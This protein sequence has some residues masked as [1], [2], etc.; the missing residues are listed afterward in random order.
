MIRAPRLIAL[1]APLVWSA[2]S[3]SDGPN[4][5]GGVRI[6]SFEVSP[7]KIRAGEE[8]TLTWTTEG[9]NGV[10][11]EPMVGLQKANGSAT[12]RPIATTTYTLTVGTGNDRITSQT[13]LTVE[14]GPPKIE[15]FS[16]TPRTVAPGEASLL[17]WACANTTSVRIEPDVGDQEPLGSIE[18]RPA[19]TTTYRLIA[20]GDVGT[21][22]QDVTVVVASGNQPVILSFTATPISVVAGDPVILA[23]QTQNADS[24]T[25]NPDVGA[26]PA[27]GQVEIR[28]TQSTVFTLVATGPGGNALASVSINVTGGGAP[29]VLR[30]TVTPDTIAPGGTSQMSWETDNATGVTIEPDIGP[31]AAKDTITI[32]PLVTT[33]YTLTAFGASSNATAEVTITVA[34]ANDPVITGFTAQ[35][36]AIVAGGSTTLSWSTQNVSTVDIDNGVGTGLQANGTIQVSP[37]QSITYTLTA[38]GTS[39]TDITESVDVTVT[40]AAPAI[41]QFTAQPTSVTAGQSATLS[42]AT[43]DATEVMIDNGV[44]MQGPSGSVMVTPAMTTTYHLT[45]TG[46][47]GSASADVTVSVQPAGAPVIQSFTASPQQIAPG[48]QV[49]LAWQTSAATT[50]RIDNGVGTVAASGQTTVTPPGTTTYTISA[51]G[52]GGTTNAQV[53][54]TVVSPNGDQCSSAFEIL[55]SGTFNGNTQTAVDD[56]F[57]SVACTGFSSRGPDQ[58]YRISL[59]SGDRLR[60]TLN[61][62]TGWDASL[63]LVTSCANI[64]QSCVAGEDNGNP[65]VVDYVAASAGTYYLIVDGYGTAGGAYTLDVALNPAPVAN[66]QCSGAIDVMRGGTFTGSTRFATHHYNP[67]ATG[68]T[69]YPETAPDVAYRVTLAAGERLQATLTASWDSA[70]YVVRDCAMVTASCVDG[71]DSGNPESVDWVATSAGN[72]FLI[73]DGYNNAAGDFSLTVSISPPVQGG[74]VCPT[75][76]AIPAGG[77]GFMSTTTGLSND[78]DPPATCAGY[79]QP[80]PDR[81]YVTTL[82]RGDVVE[83]LGQFAPTLDGSL[84]AV[85]DCASLT[86]CV[87]GADVGVDGEDE[88]LRFVA[89]QAGPHYL[90]VDA[91]VTGLAGAHELTVTTYT[92]ETC[93]TAAPLL[94]DNT[95]EWLVTTGRTNDYSPSVG[96]CT[97]STATGEDRVYSIALRAGDQLQ[98]TVA[99]N[100][101]YDPSIYLVSSCTDVS[102]SCV[103]GSD[104]TGNVPEQLA[105]V[106]QQAGTYFFVVDGFSGSDGTGTVTATVVHGDTCRDAYLVPPAGGTFRGTTSGYGADL[107]ITVRTNSCTNWQQSGSDAVYRISLANGQRVQASV[108]TT[109]DAAL[110]LITDC[111]LSATTCVA[112]QDDGNPEAIDFTNSSGATRTYY[113]VVDSWQP[114][115]T[116]SGNYTLTVT[117]Q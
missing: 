30:F 13:T 76:V 61:P 102:G 57:D 25:I 62:T 105:A 116:Y 47:G 68:C 88:A 2:C 115:S 8:A 35:P 41:Q 50:V 18:V 87:G 46:P 20:T 34:S 17:E 26:Q 113:L 45:A 91:P 63:Y 49:T 53:T 24:V 44:G 58:V 89:Q 111:A 67:G 38:H 117:I 52:P 108:S 9:A 92:A 5:N 93:A 48:G 21:T 98:A 60:A 3:G 97:G 51:T 54:V 43:T 73:V 101:G 106:V 15:R 11:I 99:P 33:T 100:T 40:T 16:A 69:G 28:P 78:Y 96:G 79:R 55:Q 31:Q 32:E 19:V 103:S 29:Q 37:A 75:A 65:E 22:S 81:V 7:A 74:E 1:L 4:P 82:G 36:L 85:T 77:G 64:A 27:N 114:G 95:A 83:A 23:W 12:V 84:Y 59:Q 6:L 90:I 66:D 70:L 104:R 14:G 39:G 42:W 112:G 94:V 109:W 10:A 72:V 71:S 107:G 56:Y 86:S 110:Y 80:G